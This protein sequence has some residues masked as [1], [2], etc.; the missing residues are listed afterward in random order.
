MMRLSESRV[1]LVWT[2]WR[3]WAS[4]QPV[5]NWVQ[6]YGDFL[7]L[8]FHK[9]LHNFHFLHKSFFYIYNNVY[10]CRMN[11]DF[12]YSTDFYGMNARELSVNPQI[13]IPTAQPTLWNNWWHYSPPALVERSVMWV[14]MPSDWTY[15]PNIFLPPSNVL[16]DTVSLHTSTV[17][18]YLY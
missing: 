1:K 5:S 12:Q 4:S 14:I 11:S 10:F 8:L 13:P 7:I 9:L 3:A 18:Q 6:R 17:I 2:I 15:R 16:Q